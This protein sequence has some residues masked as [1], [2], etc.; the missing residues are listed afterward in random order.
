MGTKSPD[1]TWVYV[2]VFVVAALMWS[3]ELMK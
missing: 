2:L 1:L 3:L